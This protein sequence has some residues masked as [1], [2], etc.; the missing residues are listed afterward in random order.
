MDEIKIHREQEFFAC[1][2]FR[3]YEQVIILNKLLEIFLSDDGWPPNRGFIALRNRSFKKGEFFDRY[4]GWFDENGKFHDNGTF[5]GEDGISYTERSLRPGTDAKPHQR[6]EVI[7]DI[8]DVKEGEAIPWFGE[9]GGGVQYELPASIDDLIEN[10]YI[11]PV[12]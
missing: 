10:G 5:V 2:F 3:V 11:K 4:G 8:P 1:R 6:Y 9:K 12:N 7:R